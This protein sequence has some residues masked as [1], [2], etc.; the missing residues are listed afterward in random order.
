M[1]KLY[2]LLLCGL[3]C[4]ANL[5]AQTWNA[6]YCGGLWTGCE[7]TDSVIATLHNDT[8]IISGTGRMMEYNSNAP[9]L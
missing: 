1:K 8:L 3:L 6:G 5:N 2:S 9:G 4:S 7:P